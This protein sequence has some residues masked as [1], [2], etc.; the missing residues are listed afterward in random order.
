[1]EEER[2]EERRGHTKL[3]ADNK[4]EDN[5]NFF[6]LQKV[7]KKTKSRTADRGTE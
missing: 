6:V 1:M 7:A 4:E 2:R 5:I 3:E